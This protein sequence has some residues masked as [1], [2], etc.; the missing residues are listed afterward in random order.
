LRSLRALPAAAIVAAALALPAA[1]DEGM[2]TFDAPPL[3][4]LQ[5]AYGFTPT[6]EWLDK[7]RLASVRFNDG[8]S[9]SFVSKDGLMITNHHVGLGCI[10]NISDPQHDY[11]SEGFLAP[12]REKEPACPGYEVNLLVATE[13]VTARVLGAV[14]PA[15]SDKEAGE[16]RKAAT[17][18]IEKE[19]ADRTRQRC[20][21]ITLYQGAEYHLYTYKKYTDVRLVFAPEEQTAFFGGD[22]DNFTFPRHDLDV[23]VFRAYENGAPAHPPAYLPWSRKGAEDG[24]L[25]FVA[26]NPGTTARLDTMAQLESERTVIQPALL[27]ALQ[28]RLGVLRGFAAGSPES[29]R[30]ANPQIRSLENSIKARSG[31]LRALQD[32]GAMAAKAEAEKNLRGRYAADPAPASGT[33]PWD[34]IAAAQKRFDD[35]FAEYRLEGFGGSRLL[36]IAG[37]IVRYGAETSKPNDVRLDEFRD[38]NLPSLENTLYSPATLY[39]DIE[40]T[41]LAGRLKE[42]EEGLG[43]DHPYVK[44]LLAGRSPEEVARAAVSATGLK[45]VAARKA[46]VAGGPAAVAA[47]KDPMIVLARAI[48]PFSREVRKFQEDDVEAVQKR[49]GE[50]IA[51]VRWKAYGKTLPP[52]ATFTLRLSYGTVKGFPAEGTI[53]APFTTFHG[54]YDRSASFG[55]RPPWNLMPRWVEHEKDLPLATPLNFVNTADTV[56]GSSGSPVINRD[57]EFVGIIF[58]G[59]IESLALDYYYTEDQA[60]SVAV[61]ARGILEA[62]RKVYDAQGLAEELAGP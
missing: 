9:G 21:V 6:R 26:G 1:A 45:E 18:R 55:N 60:R 28:R 41:T 34:T 37:T 47:S 40:G 50:R 42:A 59:N 14:K 61:D 2:W 16:A 48:D 51:A 36:G 25:V 38:S 11:V 8:G 13:D 29:A 52:D 27:E 33:D 22:P 46:L 30:R 23:C 49:A 17:A 58:D 24:D 56:G 15:M 3:Q 4:R 57:G 31:L 53:V 62:L 20:D 32:A 54:L 7:V 39:D 10:Q 12:S 35:R 44:A 5:E 43:K 19:C